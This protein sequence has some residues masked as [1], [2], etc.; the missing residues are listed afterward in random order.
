MLTGETKLKDAQEEYGIPKT[1]YYHY[2]N[3][4]VCLF[5]ISA[6]RQV[7]KTFK[8]GQLNL[9]RIQYCLSL[10]KLKTKGYQTKLLPQQTNRVIDSLN[11]EIQ[12]LGESQQGTKRMRFD[13]KPSSKMR[14]SR[15]VIRRVNARDTNSPGQVKTSKH[16]EVNVAGLS[17][18][19]ANKCDPCLAWHMFHSIC[20]LYR[21][22]KKETEKYYNKLVVLIG[23][24]DAI[25]ERILGPKEV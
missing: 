23:C 20:N 24:K 10:L 16:G 22:V 11:K 12:Q 25:G 7:T 19:S 9:S 1:L 18:Q 15:H 4:I 14:Y 3:E 8:E 5:N 21:S 2:L 17:N 13:M 6:P